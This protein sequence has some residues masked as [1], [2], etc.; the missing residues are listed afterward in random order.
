MAAEKAA[1]A[2]LTARD[3]ALAVRDKARKEVFWLRNEARQI[4][5]HVPE[6]LGT[7]EPYSLWAC[8]EPSTQ[9]FF[10]EVC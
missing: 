1:E 3:E 10:Y 6:R 2:A 8:Q 7:N 9:S 4:V 5:S